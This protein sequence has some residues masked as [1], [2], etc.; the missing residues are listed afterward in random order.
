MRKP[1]ETPASSR[2]SPFLVAPTR[3]RPGR[4]TALR[5]GGYAE[6]P[7]EKLA[8]RPRHGRVGASGL[9][10]QPAR[11]RVVRS[12]P[13][14]APASRNSGPVSLAHRPPAPAPKSRVAGSWFLLAGAW[15]KM[16]GSW[17][18]RAG[19]LVEEG[20]R[21]LA[22]PWQMVGGLCS[23]LPTARDDLSG[24]T[25]WTAP[26]LPHCA[27]RIRLWTWVGSRYTL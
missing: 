6:L 20:W 24:S 25:P 4:R 16:P 13:M 2:I 18:R 1:A 8:N 19:L 10:H 17:S 21:R 5:P 14:G 3:H 11:Q 22:R 15:S 23:P 27:L 9:P 12:R 26:A 7:Q